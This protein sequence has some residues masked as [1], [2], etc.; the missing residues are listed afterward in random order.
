MPPCRSALVM[1]RALRDF[2][3]LTGERVGFK[4]AG[5]LRTAADALR[6]LVLMKEELGRG[7]LEPDLFRI[8]ASSLLGDI[9]RRLADL[10]FHRPSPASHFA[11]A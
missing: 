11:L 6:W 8:G 10:A 5:G 1:V 9:E 3:D 2:G 7:W 4:P